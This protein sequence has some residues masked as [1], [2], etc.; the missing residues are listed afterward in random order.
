MTTKTNTKP[1]PTRCLWQQGFRDALQ[2]LSV[3]LMLVML[4]ATAAWAGATLKAYTD[5]ILLNTGGEITFMNNDPTSN[6][7]KVT[8]NDDHGDF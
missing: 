1:A 8:P 5:G 4:T 6:Y 3:T 7:V 2:R